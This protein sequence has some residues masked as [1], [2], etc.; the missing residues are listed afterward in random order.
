M[1]TKRS[2]ALVIREG[3][4]SPRW[5]LVRRPPDDDELPGVWGLPAGTLRE[6]ESVEALVARIGR[7][8]LGL[9]L[10]PGASLAEG[11]AERSRYR[12]EM[13]LVEAT[14]VS[15]E[16]RT[17]GGPVDVTQYAAWAWKPPAELATGADRGSLCCALGL[18]LGAA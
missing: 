14:V 3:D 6:D 9:D 1:T 8:K 10:L 18:E 12:L 11:T 15:G 17:G 4:E 2:L 5:L 16:P 13:R 7:D